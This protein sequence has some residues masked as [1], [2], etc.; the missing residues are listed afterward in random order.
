MVTITRQAI[1]E[2]DYPDWELV[3]DTLSGFYISS[4]GTIE[5]EGIGLL[6][7]DFANR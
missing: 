4:E 2:S 5:T 3:T 1:K 7:M 6:Q